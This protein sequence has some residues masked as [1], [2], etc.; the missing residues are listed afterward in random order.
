MRF[1]LLLLLNGCSVASTVISTGVY[2]ATDKTPTDHVL[3]YNTGLD[4]QTVRLFENQ[5]VCKPYK[6]VYVERKK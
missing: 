1:L 2:V 3:S 6:G 5:T 4:C